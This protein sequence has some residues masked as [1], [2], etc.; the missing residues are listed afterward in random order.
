MS[1]PTPHIAAAD[2]AAHLY[3]AACDLTGAEP[4]D[5]GAHNPQG[6]D[7]KAAIAAGLAWRSIRGG[8]GRPSVKLFARGIPAQVL[9][10]SITPTQLKRYRLTGDIE[11]LTDYGKR[12]AAGDGPR[13]AMA[14][15]RGGRGGDLSAKSPPAGPPKA[16]DKPH[17]KPKARPPKADGLRLAQAAPK[18]RP[19]MSDWAGAAAAAP[20]PDPEK[21]AVDR[22]LREGGKITVVGRTET[23]DPAEGRWRVMTALA[24]GHVTR[25]S[26]IGDIISQCRMWESAVTAALQG[27]KGDGLVETMNG[28][29]RLTRKGRRKHDIKAGTAGRKRA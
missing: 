4:L 21:E 6:A 18:P 28:T 11:L 7:R 26:P 24:A 23:V 27:L 22:Y 8:A 15:A 5:F 20:R 13:E 17:E 9:S 2:L 10:V 19:S 3:I 12:L 16:P 29:W 25:G 1:F 14:Y